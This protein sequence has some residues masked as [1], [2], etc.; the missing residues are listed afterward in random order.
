MWLARSVQ[1]CD[2]SDPG[3]DVVLCFEWWPPDYMIAPQSLSE[4]AT[5]LCTV[6]AP[7]I[8]ILSLGNDL[9]R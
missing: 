7:S 8:T 2:N 3:V 5:L 6:A 9:A 4:S 1:T